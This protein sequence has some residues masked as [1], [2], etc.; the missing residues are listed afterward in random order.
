MEGSTISILGDAEDLIFNTTKLINSCKE[1]YTSLEI[2]NEDMILSKKNLKEIGKICVELTEK[3][4]IMKHT[5]ELQ[6]N[7]GKFCVNRGTGHILLS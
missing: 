3:R 5:R 1:P 2:V 6:L 7:F 4:Q